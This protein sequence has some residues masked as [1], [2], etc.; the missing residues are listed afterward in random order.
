[1]EGRG[2]EG[3]E[4]TS[5]VNWEGGRRGRRGYKWSK[6]GLG[7]NLGGGLGVCDKCALPAC[8][9]ARRTKNFST[10]HVCIPSAASDFMYRHMAYYYYVS[11]LHLYIRIYLQCNSQFSIKIRVWYY[12]GIGT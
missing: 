4:G 10:V 3:G 6:L 5:G 7:I 11:V 2:G 9:C 8:K 12:C 1:M